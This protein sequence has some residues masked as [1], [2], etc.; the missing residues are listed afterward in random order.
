M[1]FKTC[2][3]QK[4]TAECVEDAAAKGIPVSA[5][6]GARILVTQLRLSNEA[7][8]VLCGRSTT[9]NAPPDAGHFTLALRTRPGKAA[10]QATLQ[11]SFSAVVGLQTPKR[12]SASP[13][14]EPAVAVSLVRVWKEDGALACVLRCDNPVASLAQAREKACHYAT[15]WLIEGFHKALKTELGAERLQLRTAH[16]LFAA[17]ALLDVVSCAGGPARTTAFSTV[18]QFCGVNA[19]P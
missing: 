15:R 5:L 17:V 19:T 4:D 7:M 13:G 1:L 11:I 3:S 18:R 9:R 8:R 12:P 2:L 10:R 16:R 6:R 14:K